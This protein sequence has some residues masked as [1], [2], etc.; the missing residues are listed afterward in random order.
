M[1]VTRRQ[2]LVR[3]LAGGAG[4]AAAAALPACAPDTA[5]A[6]LVDVAAPVNGRLTLALS[7]YPALARPGGAVRARAPGL[8]DPVLVVH[9]ADGTF[10]AMSSTCTHQGCP[11]GFE[12]GEVVCPCHASTFDLQGRVTRPPAVQGLTAYA[13]FH[14]PALDEVAVDLVAGDP[15]FPRWSE[16]AVVFPL[17]D[18]PQLA[19]A[20][21]SVVGR[22]GGAPRPL[23]LLV[24]ALAGGAHVALD[25]ICTHLGCTVGWDAGRGQ[26][27][28]PCHD[29]RYALDGTVQQGPATR[30]LGTYDVTADALAVTV[31]VPA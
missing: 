23:A 6:P 16:G 4:A 2:F 12:G 14:D 9:A 29:S 19:A 10:A 15:G 20:G 18:F 27:I 24:V 25:A 3:A 28:C 26:V 30:A 8:A 5:P 17:A 7:R 22:P 1:S 21:G 11:V 13:A 31:H